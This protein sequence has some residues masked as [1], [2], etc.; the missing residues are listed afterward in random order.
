MRTRGDLLRFMIAFALMRARKLVWGLRRGL[1]CGPGAGI[2]TL[3]VTSVTLRAGAPQLRK[4]A[5]REGNEEHQEQA[6]DHEP[7]VAETAQAL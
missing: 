5:W 1:R 7:V 6:I 4:S 2:S 3:S